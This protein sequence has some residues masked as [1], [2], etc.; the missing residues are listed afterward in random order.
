[1]MDNRY[2]MPNLN[3]MPIDVLKSFLK[4]INSTIETKEKQKYEE[5]FN[6][7]L[8]EIDYMAEKYGSYTIYYDYDGCEMTWSD[9]KNSI[10][11]YCC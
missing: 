3:D 5:D 6:R 4:E 10:K 9:L 7:V 2:S 8:Q 1:M 11:H